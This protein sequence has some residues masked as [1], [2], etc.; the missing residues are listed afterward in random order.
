MLPQETGSLGATGR[1]AMREGL[2]NGAA[3][4]PSN[5]TE[6]R[7]DVRLPRLK[8]SVPALPPLVKR[9]EKLPEAA[10]AAKHAMTTGNKAM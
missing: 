6:R 1:S 5:L 10:A 3:S 7:K 2:D 8:V 4:H 9:V